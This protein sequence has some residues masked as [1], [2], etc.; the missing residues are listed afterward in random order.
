MNAAQAKSNARLLAAM[1]MSV[2]LLRMERALKERISALASRWF[3]SDQPRY[4]DHLGTDFQPGSR[5][6]I[7]VDFKPHFVS[8][9][10][11]INHSAGLRKSNGFTDRQNPRSPNA[12]E[13]LRHALSLGR[14]DKQDVT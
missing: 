4:G 3:S 12:F 1:I 9:D 2:N 8:F 5:R 7:Q 6:S 14:T 13:N 10:K 11:E